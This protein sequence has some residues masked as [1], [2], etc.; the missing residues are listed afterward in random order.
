VGTSAHRRTIDDN[1]R[2]G[3]DMIVQRP[4]IPGRGPEGPQLSARRHADSEIV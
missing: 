4:D 3:H 1:F 2:G